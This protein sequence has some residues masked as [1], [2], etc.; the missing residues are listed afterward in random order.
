MKT[1]KEKAPQELCQSRVAPSGTF[2]SFH[3]RTC[4]KPA[5]GHLENGKPACGIHLRAEATRIARNAKFNADWR[6]RS[7][8]ADEVEAFA[9]KHDIG[10][11]LTTH[12]DTRRVSIS[13]FYSLISWTKSHGWKSLHVG[14][15]NGSAS[16]VLPVRLRGLKPATGRVPISRP[17][18]RGF[19]L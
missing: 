17:T 12:S 14:I 7:A 13:F 8:F 1:K 10:P 19:P 18:P 9:V 4:G 16:R 11:L 6:V 2:G 5:K 15:V 3:S